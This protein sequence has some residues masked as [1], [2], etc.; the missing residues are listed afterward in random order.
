[1]IVLAAIGGAILGMIVNLLSDSL[2]NHRRAM[3]FHCHSCG[4]QRE[5]AAWSGVIGLL[6]GKRTCPKCNTPRPWR[7]IAVEILLTAG[8]VGLYLNDPSFDVFL[9]SVIIITIYLLIT[10]IDIEHRL[11]LHIV[12][13]PSAIVIGLIGIIDPARGLTKTII[14]GLGG[15]GIFLALYYLGQGF[16]ALMSKLRGTQIDEVAFGFGDVTL[17]GVIG[18]TVGWPGVIPALVIGIIAAGFFSFLYIFGMILRRNYNPFMP[19]P[20]GP[21]MVLGCMI[22]YFGGRGLF[23]TLLTP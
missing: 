10:V 12:S 9:P 6:L 11:I 16:A 21:F 23:T 3:L 18:L 1:M 13:F 7:A 15:F 22:T 19:I 2:P 17:A 5:L 4:S 20:Y 14:G 8:V